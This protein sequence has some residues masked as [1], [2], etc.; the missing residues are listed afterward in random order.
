MQGAR[1]SVSLQLDNVT[2][3]FALGRGRSVTAVERFDL[4][5]EPGEFVALI[6]PSGCGK[7][8]VLRMLG[9]L[10]EPTDGDVRCD[11][12]QP[13]DLIAQH[14]L[15][16]AF[17]DHALLPWLDVKHN[18]ALPSRLAQR[19]VDHARVHRLIKLVGLEGFENARPKHL[20]GG[21]RQRV[22]IAR[23]LVLEPALLLLDEPFGALDAITRRRLNFELAHIWAE[24]GV[25][26]LLVTH[27][28]DEAALLAD[29]VVVMSGRPGQ[30]L[31][32]TP[33]PLERPRGRET[34]ACAEFAEQ[35]RRLF[36][37]LDQAEA[38]TE[39]T[40]QGET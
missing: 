37:L 15:G 22:A 10:D 16:F 31:A 19:K 14:R 4:T 3:R 38:G 32:D 13:Q 40:G 20:S 29:R 24:T 12:G 30:V 39:A 26:T 7:S 21:M 28:V 5:V 18:I 2:K 6:G 36:E 25:T 8:T 9:G 1:Q 11:E 33:I 34:L 27:S 35:Q 23:A 17:Q